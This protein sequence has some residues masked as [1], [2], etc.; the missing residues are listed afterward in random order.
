[1]ACFLVGVFFLVRVFWSFWGCFFC[2]LFLIFVM[3]SFYMRV[4]WLYY[5]YTVFI[6]CLSEWKWCEY[7]VIYPHY[8]PPLIWP[9]SM[10][11][12]R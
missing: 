4:Y 11:Q 7:V 2:D 6:F 3:F 12:A 1:L 10:C 5:L 9:K 8:P